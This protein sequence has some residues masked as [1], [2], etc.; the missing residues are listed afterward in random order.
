VLQMLGSND[1]YEGLSEPAAGSDRGSSI[2]INHYIDI[3]KRRFFYFLIPFGVISIVG[4]YG[5]AIQ[6]PSYLS[7]GKI[8]LEG[9]TIAVDIVR[10][11]ITA[12]IN[13]RIQLIQQRVTTRDTLLSVANKF[14]LF[15]QRPGVVD[16]MRKS[17]QIKPVVEGEGLLRQNSPAIAFTVGFE[18]EN[19]EIAM[20]VAN[21]FVTLT[22]G[23]DARSRTSR[24]TEAVKIL[25]DEAKDLESKLE[26]TQAQILEIAQRARD[27]I[28]EIPD[29]QKSDLAARAA[30]KAEL[31]QKSAVY[32]DAHP[33][34]I[35]LKKRIAA[36]EK[37]IKEPSQ[38]QKQSQSTPDEIDVLKRQREALER[39][40][41]EANGKLAN[42]LLG[43]SQE[44]RSERM[45][46]IEA[47][48][49]P[50]Q[51]LKSN[52]LK[53]VGMFFAAAAVLGVGA[54]VGIELLDGSIRGRH[55]LADVVASPLV[56]CIPYIPT[57][58]DII[59]AKLRVLF[60]IVGVAI[61]LSAWS[62]LTAAIMLNLP[63]DA[64]F[65]KVRA[66]LTGFSAADR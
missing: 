2:H 19:P 10:P 41:V 38:A 53:M 23:E 59:R 25:T 7:E 36:M 12:T 57:R 48:S 28:P 27:D 55:Q 44:Q 11:V 45:Q 43:E 52:R 49:L 26:F 3:F 31:V 16:A 21:E 32:S 6:K 5:A 30:L 50:Q 56:V 13:E 15:P 42:A 58:A 18:Y 51:P 61:I 35:A 47:P 46:V 39:R 4:L 40:L 34:V 37:V 33:A 20:R 54:A 64:A 24:A 22:V 1:S 8:L 62:G 9:Q 29:Q 14:G 63:V 65:D 17:V 60:A 66:D